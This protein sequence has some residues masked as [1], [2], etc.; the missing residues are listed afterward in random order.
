[1]RIRSCH[2]ILLLTAAALASCG[3]GAGQ[4]AEPGTKP[5]KTAADT[6]NGPVVKP[7]A[8][9]GRVEG[10]LRDGKRVGQWVSYFAHGG[11]RSRITYV[12]GVENGQTEVFHESGLTYYLGQ[13][14]NGRQVGTWIFYDEDG[15]EVKRAYYDSTGMLLRQEDR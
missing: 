10:T 12:D 3:G 13:Y 5:V 4:P 2:P 8:D 11:P 14:H 15:N 9:G 1:M 6:L 7:L